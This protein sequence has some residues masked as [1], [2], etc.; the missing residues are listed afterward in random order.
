MASVVVKTGVALVLYRININKVIRNILIVA[1]VLV[2]VM[3]LVLG[4][5][6]AFQCRPLSTVWGKGTGSCFS[7]D[8]II[9]TGI[10]FSVMDI[11][12]NWL[13]SLMPIPM[14]YNIQMNNRVK[15]SLVVI[16]GLGIL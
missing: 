1:M 15:V 13:Y 8:T 5:L 16:L 12:S 4:L 14:L 11:V 9:R 3:T 10:A 2:A 7:F 6:I